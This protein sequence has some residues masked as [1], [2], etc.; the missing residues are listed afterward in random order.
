MS[1]GL[2]RRPN[3]K[4]QYNQVTSCTAELNAGVRP[5]GRPTNGAFALAHPIT[6]MQAVQNQKI[7]SAIDRIDQA[8]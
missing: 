3:R 6:A 2:R 4:N 7:A 1:R 8:Q 5:G